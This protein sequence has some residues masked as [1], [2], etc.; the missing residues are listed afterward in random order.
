MAPGCSVHLVTTITVKHHSNSKVVINQVQHAPLTLF[1][2]SLHMSYPLASNHIHQLVKPLSQP[3]IKLNTAC[4]TAASHNITA[5]PTTSAKYPN[6][7]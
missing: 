1:L 3:P 2:P 6:L 4:N 5:P 7:A